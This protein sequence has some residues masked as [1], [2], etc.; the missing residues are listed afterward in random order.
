MQ[1]R[2]IF[3]VVALCAFGLVFYF[4][5]WGQKAFVN[6]VLSSAMPKKQFLVRNVS[7]TDFPATFMIGVSS[8]AYQI[9]GGW[10]EGGKTAS[11]WDDFVHFRPNSVDDNSTADIGP[12]SF[13]NFRDDVAALKLVGVNMTS[14][15]Q[16]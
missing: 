11:I 12:D 4:D 15:P 1:N 10:N 3:S 16:R 6:M 2:V 7:K 14:S 8:S 13:H 5:S 9:E